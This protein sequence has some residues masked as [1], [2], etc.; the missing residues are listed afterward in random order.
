VNAR[1]ENFD[2]F[3]SRDDK[4][5][6]RDDDDVRRRTFGGKIGAPTVDDSGTGKTYRAFVIT[7][8]FSAVCYIFTTRF[9]NKPCIIFS[10]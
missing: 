8:R 7:R 4:D 3:R 6:A 10:M 9:A 1:G 5:G 2:G